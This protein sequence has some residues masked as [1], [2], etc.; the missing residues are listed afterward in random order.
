MTQRDLG[1][2]LFGVPILITVCHRMESGQ[3]LKQQP[4]QDSQRSIAYWLTLH[5]L[6]NLLSYPA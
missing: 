4:G 6:F 2:G 5:G 3:G 1:K